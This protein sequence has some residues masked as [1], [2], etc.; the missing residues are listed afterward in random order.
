MLKKQKVMTFQ[1]SYSPTSQLYYTNVPLIETKEYKCLGNVIDYKGNFNRATQELT[2]KGLKVLFA[3]RSRFANFQSIPI[4]LSCKLFA[5]LVRPVPL[6]NSEIWFMD[7]YLSIFR[8]LNRSNKDNIFCDTLSLEEKFQYESVHNKFC[9]SVLGLKKT[10][11]NI[12]AKSELGRFPLDSFIKIQVMMYLTTIN[13]SDIYPLV[14]EAFNINKYL[15]TTKISEEFNFDFR[16]RP[17]NLEGGRGCYVFFF[18][19]KYFFRATRK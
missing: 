8:A 17:F 5:I 1:K 4:T 18:V 19:P 16:D 11:S 15:L 12:A 6:Y 14:K 13:L 10:A 9:K 3:L 7:D 2:K